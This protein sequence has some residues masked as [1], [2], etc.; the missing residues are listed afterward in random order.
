[1]GQG[2]E[3]CQENSWAR[4]PVLGAGFGAKPPT[5]DPFPIPTEPPAPMKGPPGR[6]PRSPGWSALGRTESKHGPAAARCGERSGSPGL[7]GLGSTWPRSCSE[8]E[9]PAAIPFQRGISAALPEPLECSKRFLSPQGWAKHTQ[10]DNSQAVP[11]VSGSC[12]RSF[13]GIAVFSCCFHQDQ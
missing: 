4:A 2:D 1:M 5:L 9:A 6:C 8:G 3:L 7:P 11:T 10:L 12:V 13:P